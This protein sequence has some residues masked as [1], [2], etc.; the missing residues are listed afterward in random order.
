MSGAP[1]G[2]G[3][4]GSTARA[5]G[6][7]RGRGASPV[8]PRGGAAPAPPSV[9]PPRGHSARPEHA[10]LPRG[11]REGRGE[12][13]G[14]EK[15]SSRGA[16]ARPHSGPR[17]GFAWGGKKNRGRAGEEERGPLE[18]LGGPRPPEPLPGSSQAFS[19]QLFFPRKV[20]PIF[21]QAADGWESP[22]IVVGG[23]GGPLDRRRGGGRSHAPT[24]PLEDDFPPPLRLSRPG[25]GKKAW[26][27]SRRAPG[28][29]WEEA[30][31][32]PGEA[33]EEARR[34]LG[35]RGGPGGGGRGGGGGGRARGR[36][37]R[38]REE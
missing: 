17:E 12:A 9:P 6:S 33:W 20:F 19:R 28:E 36:G 10:P 15:S 32:A 16:A 14:K 5:R 18:P 7:P 1:T 4:A 38:R 13:A 31:R 24:M 25:G 22:S 34:S 8:G 11:R 3:P 35:G 26:E 30:R 27:K 37:G 29:A 2:L 23:D 21:F